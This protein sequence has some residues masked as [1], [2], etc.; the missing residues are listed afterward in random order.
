MTL[1]WHCGPRVGTQLNSG[2]APRRC[3]VI[4]EL[5]SI[6]R[7]PK[8]LHYSLSRKQE[9]WGWSVQDLW[10]ASVMPP[11]G[12]CFCLPTPPF[13]VMSAVP[14]GCACI[15]GGRGG[16]RKRQ[17]QETS[18]YISLAVNMSMATPTDGKRGNWVFTF[19]RLYGRGRQGRNRLEM[20]VG[21]LNSGVYHLLCSQD[22]LARENSPACPYSWPQD[23]AF[24]PRG[25]KVDGWE[26][27]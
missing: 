23:V 13:S 19:Y 9:V 16:E 17:H 10:G 15:P 18:A 7:N 14:P 27:L 24:M 12:G 5:C 8:S 1:F 6:L 25:E 20:E 11:S 21:Q 3:F 4:V 2:L 26:W 22:L